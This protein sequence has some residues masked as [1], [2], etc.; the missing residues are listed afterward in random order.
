MTNHKL[1]NKIELIRENV[2]VTQDIKDYHF[3]D[4]ILFKS[5]KWYDYVYDIFTNKDHIKNFKIRFG[6][7]PLR[8]MISANSDVMIIGDCGTNDQYEKDA[9]EILIGII[10]QYNRNDL[11]QVFF[12]CYPEDFVSEAMVSPVHHNLINVKLNLI[13]ITVNF[14]KF[15]SGCDGVH[16][17]SKKIDLTKYHDITLIDRSF[18]TK[19]TEYMNNEELEI[20]NLYCEKLIEYIKSMYPNSVVNI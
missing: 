4:L 15:L 1:L 5:E 8:N 20:F 18:R 10:S 17:L 3:S 19:Y 11:Y 12:T 2:I 7:G 16:W 14:L 9:Y 13:F 6:C